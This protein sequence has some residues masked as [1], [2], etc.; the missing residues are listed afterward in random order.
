MS[1]LL[2]NPTSTHLKS[3]HFII[4]FSY[5][6]HTI[7]SQLPGIDHKRTLWLYSETD[8]SAIQHYFDQLGLMTLQSLSDINIVWDYLSNLLLDIHTKCIPCKIQYHKNPQDGLTLRS[9]IILIV[10]TLSDAAVRI[11]QLLLSRPN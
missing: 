5:Q 7:K 3:G 9:V 4:S 1:D 6:L 2:I 10:I 11:I 8:Q